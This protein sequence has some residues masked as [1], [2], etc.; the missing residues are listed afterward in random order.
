MTERCAALLKALQAL[1]GD[2]AVLVPCGPDDP[3][4]V[5]QQTD[6][7]GRYKGHALAI[8]RPNSTQELAATVSL[9]AQFGVSIV[10]QG[11]HTGLVGGGV[12]DASGEQIVLSLQ[13]LNRILSIDTINLSMTVQAGCLLSTV[14]EA[15]DAAGL[16]FPLS[17]ASEGSCT[18]GGNLATNAGGTQVLRY[19]TAR[20]LCL[21]LEAVTA[22]GEV[23]PQLKSLR[24][25]NT[26]YDLRDLLIGSEG[27]LAI[28][29]AA[30]LRLF[31][32]PNSRLAALIA[33]DTIEQALELLA[34]ARATLDASLTG[35]EI[36]H[37]Y[38]VELTL[39]HHPDQAVA[40]SQL[41]ASNPATTRPNQV[42]EWIVLLDAA[43]PAAL[44]HLQARVEALL[45][46]A[47]QTG[48]VHHVC[49]SQTQT[50][51]KAMWAL[52]EAI[53][54]SEKAEAQMVKHDVGVPTSQIAAFINLAHA[55]LTATFP[56]CRIVCFGHLGDGN[57]HY[58]VQAPPEITGFDFLA[59][60]E[61]DVNQI[62][63]DITQQLGGTISAEHG[64]GQLRKDELGQRQSSVSTNWMRAIKK[65][66]DPMNTLNP[67]RLVP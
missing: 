10:A 58:N 22:Q 53:P 40:A 45:E 41:I 35:F 62:V 27:T 4:F 42:P 39:K 61:H 25:D 56:S 57:L 12:P 46:Q 17:L 19:G 26:G 48:V 21:G 55:K 66:L 60:H 43:S 28:I 63:Y 11:G 9:C 23:W 31:P 59:K 16:L 36:M 49:V 5:R 33:C 15:A 13:R 24:K 6:W 8:V 65:A 32:K 37:R 2:A 67:G 64:I 47:I 20:E 14:Q 3:T 7:R 54:L 29:T 30:S 51:Y 1:L 38:P 50:Q 44:E 52:R 34:N 18:I